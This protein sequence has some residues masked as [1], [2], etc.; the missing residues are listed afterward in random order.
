MAIDNNEK[1]I[2]SIVDILNVTTN[3]RSIKSIVDILD[4]TTNEKNIME[5]KEKILPIL[6]DI[7][8]IKRISIA[9]INAKY[10]TIMRIIYTDFKTDFHKRYGI[11]NKYLKEHKSF[12]IPVAVYP[13]TVKVDILQ[14]KRTLYM[15][16]LDPLNL[17][18]A[19]VKRMIGDDY[20]GA[21]MFPIVLNGKG[22]GVLSCYLTEDE[23]LTEHDIEITKQ[24]TKIL[25]LLIEI[26]RKNEII[27]SIESKNKEFAEALKMQRELMSLNNISFL[28]GAR[29][30]F[31]YQIGNGMDETDKL[32]SRL[33][34]DYYEAIKLSESKAL[35]FFADVMGHGIMSN[36][37]VPL[38]K[39]MFKM[40]VRENITSPSEIL[41]NVSKL[42]YSDLDSVGMFITCRVMLV[43]FLEN[44]ICS[45]NAGHTVP[46]LY[47]F[48]RDKITYLDKDRGKP[49]GVD[50]EYSYEEATYE[51][52]DE[53]IVFMYTDGIYEN[54]NINGQSYKESNIVE[55]MKANKYSDSETICNDIL[56]GI[57]TF[58]INR[59]DEELDDMMIVLI[60]NF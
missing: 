5:A 28:S 2:K 13:D 24:I 53:A 26:Y 55:I 23:Y 54:T 22:I 30:S 41:S 59:D 46:L 17:K 15:K 45:A 3:E 12:D 49:L 11:E 40:I 6:L 58:I 48:R 35:L 33:G 42:I 18:H 32:K 27:S 31:N 29:I 16:K 52:D 50:A 51:M 19:E 25:A 8:K 1:N 20:D 57:K 44:K 43:D 7:L 56:D 37:F 10:P 47:S 21:A 9:I 39:G 38:L 34:G 60:K 14:K 36:Y 4:I